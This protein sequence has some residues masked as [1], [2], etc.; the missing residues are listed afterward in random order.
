MTI[1]AT[2]KVGF[3]P[4]FK[5][6]PVEFGCSVT[7]QRSCDSTIIDIEIDKS[8]IL[9]LFYQMSDFERDEMTHQI[10]RLVSK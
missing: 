6:K 5:F 7:V 8:E 2:P 1:I 3:E 10:L 9:S 4:V